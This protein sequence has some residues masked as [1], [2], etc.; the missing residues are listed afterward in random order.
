VLVFASRHPTDVE[1]SVNDDDLF[2]WLRGA[3]AS[4][5]TQTRRD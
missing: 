1:D 5:T 3:T 4:M 2:V